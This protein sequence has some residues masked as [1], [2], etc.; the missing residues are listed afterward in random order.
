[1]NIGTSC[2]AGGA[3]VAFCGSRAPPNGRRQ[4]SIATSGLEAQD[5]VSSSRSAVSEAALSL[6]VY[7]LNLVSAVSFIV[8]A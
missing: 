5:R 8:F 6:Y 7:C 3:S 2:V 4:I 1:M